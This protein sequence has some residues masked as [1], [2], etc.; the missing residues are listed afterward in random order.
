MDSWFS[1]VLIGIR[2][3]SLE[4]KGG[5]KDGGEDCIT[6]HLLPLFDVA[7]TSSLNQIIKDK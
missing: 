7:S 2:E 1:A 4:M 5:K 3:E 6:V